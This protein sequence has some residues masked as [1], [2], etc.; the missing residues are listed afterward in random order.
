MMTFGRDVWNGVWFQSE[1]PD[2]LSCAL[3]VGNA[4]SVIQQEF[5]F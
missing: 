3:V 1:S 5:G 2:F 4:N